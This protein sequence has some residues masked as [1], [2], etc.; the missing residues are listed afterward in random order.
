M[1]SK[2]EI[3]C[4]CIIV[5]LPCV[6]DSGLGK[7][8]VE[9]IGSVKS[10]RASILCRWPILWAA[11][12]LWRGS[13]V[14]SSEWKMVSS[15]STCTVPKPF[16]NGHPKRTRQDHNVCSKMACLCASECLYEAG[17]RVFALLYGGLILP[18]FTYLQPPLCFTWPYLPFIAYLQPLCLES[19][20]SVSL[21]L[22]GKHKIAIG[23]PI[24]RNV[25]LFEL[26]CF[27]L[28]MQS[29]N[30]CSTGNFQD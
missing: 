7:I 21:G 13:L 15:H 27:Q 30:M 20:Q 10:P 18:L 17:S 26:L 19:A 1:R 11:L 14:E 9:H 28:F 3:V 25:A 29:C 6:L 5:D 24:F 16:S 22:L 12:Q 4:V 8:S 2:R 23:R